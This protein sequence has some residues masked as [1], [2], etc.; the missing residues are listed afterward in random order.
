[1]ADYATLARDKYG[2]TIQALKPSTTQ[3][4]AYTG[5]AGTI[6]NVVGTPVVYVVAT[7]ACFVTVGS[8]PTAT[9]TTGMYLPGGF[10]VTLRVEPGVDKVSAIQQATGGTL[11]VTEMA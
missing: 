6:A 1:M 9:T 8:A 11:Y 5:T 2:K 10:P 3:N 4:V 7:T